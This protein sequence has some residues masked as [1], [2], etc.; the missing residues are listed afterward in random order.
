[1]DVVFFAKILII[2]C[3]LVSITATGSPI[4]EELNQTQ[5]HQMLAGYS[6]NALS[7]GISSGTTSTPSN[8]SC[9]ISYGAGA[10]QSERSTCPWYNVENT[11]Y[12]RYPQT[13][14][15]ARCYDCDNCITE[16]PPNGLHAVWECE[17]VLSS[18]WVLQI[19]YS[20]C[21]NGIYQYNA[22]QNDIATACVC[23]RP[24]QS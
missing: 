17:H 22:V 20:S 10:P 13:L 24:R 9:P 1:M 7:L 18:V 3:T 6:P 11:D 8:T 23:G 14:L 19:N 5:L 2:Y 4:C 15:E 21:V 16:L 12:T